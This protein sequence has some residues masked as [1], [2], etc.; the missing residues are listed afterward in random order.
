M[1]SFLMRR[2][3]GELPRDSV[4]KSVG[5]SV[6]KLERKLA[7]GGERDLAEMAVKIQVCDV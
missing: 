7:G 1:A 3:V 5:K 4:R 2:R 6:G